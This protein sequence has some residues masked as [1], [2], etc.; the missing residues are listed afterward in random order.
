MSSPMVRGI[1]RA[2]RRTAT[3]AVVLAMPAAVLAAVAPATVA[4]AT[5]VPGI[6][7]PPNNPGTGLPPGQTPLT[8]GGSPGASVRNASA[9]VGAHLTYYGGRVISNAQA[10]Q[11]LYGGT[12]S[13]YVPGI[14]NTASPSM[15]TFLGGVLNS[16]YVDWLTEYNTGSLGTNQVI[17]RGSFAGRFAISPSSANNGSTIDDSNIQAELI[18]QI[19]AGQLPSPTT[20][21]AGNVNTL[22]V[23]DFPHGKTITQG[24]STSLVQFCAY[25][26]TLT[27]NGQHL[28]YTVQPDLSGFNMRG[29]GSNGDFNNS[30]AITSHEVTESITDAEVGLAPTVGPPLAWY[31]AANGEIGDICNGQDG[32]VVGGDGV[33]YTV[34]QEFSNVANN[35]IVQRA[36]TNDFSISANPATV[37]VV[38]GGST[39]STITTAVTSGSAQTV[40]LSASG[41]PSGASASFNPTSVTAGGSSTLTLSTTA[42]APPGTYSVSVTGTGASATHATT[43]TLNITSSSGSVVVNGDFETGTFNGWTTGGASATISNTAHTGA[44]SA[45]LGKTTP[46]NGDSTMRQTV[47]VPTGGTLSFWYK[48]SCPDSVTYDWSLMQVETTGGTVLT[49]P[50]AKTCVTNSTWVHV[51]A[52]L[53]AYAGQSV[54]LLFTSHDDNYGTDPTYTLFDDISLA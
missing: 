18:A 24:G 49:T 33:T 43:V 29:C 35:C 21:A 31:D 16:P 4:S 8:R 27:R 14:W 45:Q 12:A 20:D 5:T 22:Y 3:I 10:V 19:N 47:V 11:V 52:N 1:Q 42:S 17:G 41:L 34:Q 48:M 26:G 28:Y 36:V 23:I 51:T 53:G 6:G 2:V 32:T 30:T 7:H 9:P 40:S 54:V 39:N 13:Q 46:T 44:H 38:Q 50:L 25:H 37:S 15:S